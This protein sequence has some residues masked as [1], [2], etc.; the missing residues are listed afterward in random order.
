MPVFG[1]G[2]QTRAFSYIADVAPLI[3]RCGGAPEA[4]NAVFNVG[5]DTATSVRELAERISA[6]FDRPCEIAHLPAR[7]EVA[8]AAASHDRLRAA[9]ALPPAVALE[10]G[11]TRMAAWVR[12]RPLSAP[13]PFG[14]IEVPRGLPAS[15]AALT[16]ATA[17]Q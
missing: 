7:Q 17:A 16:S 6:L 14:A 13:T 2:S 11:L 3:A 5:A 4:R 1:D 15:W 10:A 9:F 8:H 12:S